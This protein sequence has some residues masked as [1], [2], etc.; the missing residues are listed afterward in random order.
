MSAPDQLIPP[1][2][3]NANAI[4][5]ASNDDQV[6]VYWNG[7]PGVGDNVYVKIPTSRPS[8]GPTDFC[9]AISYGGA[10]N[11]DSSLKSVVLPGGFSYYIDLVNAS[12][13]S[14]GV[15]VMHKPRIGPH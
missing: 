9:D 4:L 10:V 12:G 15:D 3:G 2:T 11:L 5:A 6:L 14:L 7:T 1:S 8:G 13:A